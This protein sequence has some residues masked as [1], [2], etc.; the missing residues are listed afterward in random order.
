MVFVLFLFYFYY[1]NGFSI[2]YYSIFYGSFGFDVATDT[3]DADGFCDG[4][5][6]GYGRLVF[7]RHILRLEIYPT[8]LRCLMCSP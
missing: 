5:A 1:H 6:G 2:Y 8:M 3:G 7:Y 4:Y